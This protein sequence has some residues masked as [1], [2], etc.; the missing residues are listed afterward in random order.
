MCFHSLFSWSFAGRSA[1]TGSGSLLR[2]TRGALSWKIA[3]HLFAQSTRRNCPGVVTLKCK[4]RRFLLLCAIHRP[5]DLRALDG[6]LREVENVLLLRWKKYWQMNCW[7]RDQPCQ[8]YYHNL[9][10]FETSWWMVS[11]SLNRYILEI[12]KIFKYI[13]EISQLYL[14]D[15]GMNIN[16]DTRT[17]QMRLKYIWSY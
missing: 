9:W 14:M 8:I 3:T 4:C 5:L 2:G 17:L 7:D 12:F 13:L 10:I 16:L 1:Q 6:S 15:N 11:Q